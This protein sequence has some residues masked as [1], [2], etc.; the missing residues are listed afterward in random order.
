[1]IKFPDSLKIG[2]YTLKILFPYHF[3]ERVDLNGQCDI[4]LSEIRISVC[5]ACGN[6]RNDSALLVTFW[7]EVFHCIDRVYFANKMC[8]TKDIENL[9]EGLAQGMSQIFID[10]M[11]PQMKEKGIL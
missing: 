8:E 6:Q 7:H 5:D 1:M 10:N 3:K 2:A 4:D 11:L 9:V